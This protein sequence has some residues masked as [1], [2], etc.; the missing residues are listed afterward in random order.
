[1]AFVLSPQPPIAD[2]LEDFDSFAKRS[3]GFFAGRPVVVDIAHMPPT[4][5]DLVHLVTELRRRHITIM[6]LDGR[7][8]GELGADARGLPP[9]LSGGKEIAA[10]AQ[11]SAEAAAA[12]EPVASGEAPDGAV[13]GSGVTVEAAVSQAAIAAVE[14]AV[15]PGGTETLIIDQPVRSGQSIVHLSGDVTVIGQV[16]S[17]AEII[18][19]G[20]IHV[21]GALRGRAI[22]GSSGDMNAR[23]FC[24]ELH[25]ELIAINGLYKTNED[26]ERAYVGRAV[27]A[28]LDGDALKMA[29]LS[30]KGQ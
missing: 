2:W 15:E 19:S 11:M 22:A 27:H 14:A 6:G 4:R 26:L 24:N 13:D 16:A 1:M 20:S 25:A 18:A 23:I 30:Q 7:A 3:P 8:P 5:P 10:V 9:I 21:Y 28:W 29:A 17:G 12:V